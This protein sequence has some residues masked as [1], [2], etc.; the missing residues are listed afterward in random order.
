MNKNVTSAAT[1]KL[2]IFVGFVWATLVGPLSYVL[3]LVHIGATSS[4]IGMVIA[5]CA[6]IGMVCQPLWGLLSDKIR[7]PR[8][9]LSGCLGISALLFGCVLL[10]DNFSIVVAIFIVEA[11]FRCSIIALLD[12]HTLSEMSTIPGLQYS[13]IR[14]AGSMFF[15]ITSLIYSIV[16][17]VHGVMSII[18]I[19]MFFAMIAV[20]LGFFVAKGK[21]EKIQN[22]ETSKAKKNLRKEALSLL[23]NK[24]YLLFLGYAAFNSLALMPLFMF[25]IEYVTDMGGGPENVQMIAFMRC[26]FEIPVF[27]LI[28]KFGKRLSYKK[29]LIFGL[30]LSMIYVSGLLFSN[31]MFWLTASYMVGAIAFIFALTGRLRYI[32]E[33]TPEIVRSTS[34]TL[35]GAC[36]MGVGAV[37]GNLLAGFIIGMYGTQAFSMVSIA[38]LS[39]AAIFLGLLCTVNRARERV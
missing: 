20:S 25:N 13:S 29:F 18:P 1:L 6:I 8:L 21:S 36:E 23:K 17:S 31:N 16:I 34:I 10:T 4:Q 26:V 27:I 9:V 35:I 12:S 22:P 39:I 24:S 33:K 7:S 2:F 30:C 11:V 15:G 14:L 38:A 19:T 28:S 32:F 5:T 37:V 3:I